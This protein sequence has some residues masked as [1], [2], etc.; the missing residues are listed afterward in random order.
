MANL[1]KH[2]IDSEHL[3]MLVEPEPDST[4]L[5]EEMKQERARRFQTLEQEVARLKAETEKAK[6]DLRCRE[7]VGWW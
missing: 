6:K 5:N 3:G 1:G 7:P 2:S 4:I